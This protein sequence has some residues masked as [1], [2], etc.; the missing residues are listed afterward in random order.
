MGF[1]EGVGSQ[2]SPWPSL[3]LAVSLT[4]QNR[5]TMS[6]HAW[7]ILG[8]C[9]KHE[10]RLGISLDNTTGIQDGKRHLDEEMTIPMSMYRYCQ[11]IVDPPCQLS[12]YLDPLRGLDEC[13]VYLCID[14]VGRFDRREMLS[15]ASLP[16]LAVLEL[17]ELEPMGDGIDDRLIQSWKQVG[18]DTAFHSLR[19]LRISSERHA[20]SKGSLNIVLNFPQLEIFDITALNTMTKGR[21]LQHDWKVTEPRD[22]ESMFASYAVGYLE[23]GV[24]LNMKNGM[25]NLRTVFEDDRRRVAWADDPREPL[26]HKWHDEQQKARA[27]AEQRKAREDEERRKARNDEPDLPVDYHASYED[28]IVIGSRIDVGEPDY[29]EADYDGLG[30]SIPDEE[31]CSEQGCSGPDSDE[32]LGD[33]DRVR[34]EPYLSDYLDE[35]WRAFLQGDSPLSA[36]AD[37]QAGNSI[38][39]QQ[40]MTDDQVFWFLALLSQRKFD[41]RY[42]AAQAQVAGITLPMDRFV[43]LRLRNPSNN[44]GQRR[45]LLNLKR[46]I[47]SRRSLESLLDDW[48]TTLP[49]KKKAD[50]PRDPARDPAPSWA[51]RADDRRETDLKPRSKRQKTMGDLFSSLGM[52]GGRS[53]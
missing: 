7:N 8:A 11:E 41:L 15:L 13:L 44:A 46:R 33:D 17:I 36:T 47:Y 21:H 50:T 28:D 34:E 10:S 14:N 38:Q 39:H 5:R 37:T 45:R 20:V 16:Q 48:L 12:A 26:Y 31:G 18:G 49:K 43:S 3:S 9:L 53:G 23:G 6:L 29:E 25:D 51:P 40:D 22:S 35:G 52:P 19:V 30:F 32:D 2:V 24:Q 4:C 27:E 42:G 1:V